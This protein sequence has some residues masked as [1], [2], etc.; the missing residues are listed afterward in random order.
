MAFRNSAPAS[1]G[2]AVTIK[3][4]S[5]QRGEVPLLAILVVLG[6]VSFVVVLAIWQVRAAREANWRIWRLSQPDVQETKGTRKGDVIKRTGMRGG[7]TTYT[8]YEFDYTYTVKGSTYRNPAVLSQAPED[9]FVVVYVP[10][11]PKLAKIKGEPDEAPRSAGFW[12]TVMVIV[13]FGGFVSL[14][15][16]L[17]SL[18]KK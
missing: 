6:I 10:D 4:R 18:H 9:H 12:N 7:R 17:S 5:A 11:N 15:R 3:I 14:I 16:Y 1:D 2:R 8:Q 13:V